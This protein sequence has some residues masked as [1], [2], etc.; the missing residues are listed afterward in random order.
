[1]DNC[2]MSCQVMAYN[3]LIIINLYDMDYWRHIPWLPFKEIKERAIFHYLDN[4]RP[5]RSLCSTWIWWLPNLT[6]FCKYVLSKWR[7]VWTSG[8]DK[9]YL[10][11]TSHLATALHR[12]RPVNYKS[13][14]T[15]FWK[16][17]DLQHWLRTHDV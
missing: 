1:M 7:N 15:S 2:W 10:N 5:F 16:S 14:G 6:E 4:I 11:N 3:D 13:H 12:T 8:S 17:L 9:N